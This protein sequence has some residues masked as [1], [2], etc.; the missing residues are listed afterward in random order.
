MLQQQLPL[1]K[2]SPLKADI[3]VEQ[4][5]QIRASANAWISKNFPTHRKFLSHSKP[6]FSE[7]DG[8]WLTT[9]STKNLNCDSAIVGR[10]LIDDDASIVQAAEPSAVY[11]QLERLIESNESPEEL[12]TEL[13]GRSFEFR[14][15]DG[16]EEAAL[17]PDKSIDLVLTD[18]PYGISKAY[19][20]ESQV[21]RRLRKDGTDFIMPKGNFGEWDSEVSP[22]TWTQTLLPKVRGWF[23][24]FC[25]Q[26]QIGEYCDILLQHKFV[27]VGTLVW[28]KTNPVPFNHKYKPINAWEALV[29]GKRPGIKFNGRVVHNVFL[30][31]SP[32]PQQRIHPT[33]KP[34][35]LME[36][37]VELFSSE[38][39]TVYDPFAGSATTVIAAVQKGRKAL[40][41]EKDPEIYQA[42]YGRLKSM[43][44]DS[45]NV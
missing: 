31:K 28:Q 18:P 3:L 39:E 27:A 34:L 30:H 25:A 8:A 38:G 22:A 2:V 21:S 10:L 11:Q 14:M 43:L 7:A 19:I 24:T 45:A 29:V 35:G 26:A 9:I 41:F 6:V 20:C 15:G 5:L 16:I 44:G 13:V 42:A 32:S 37:F 23:V 36:R 40:A 12:E 4:K 17:I 1:E 33:Q